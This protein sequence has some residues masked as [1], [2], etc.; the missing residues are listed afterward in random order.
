MVIYKLLEGSYSYDRNIEQGENNLYSQDDVMDWA[1]DVANMI[2]D[3]SED[4]ECIVVDD[5]ESALNVLES[6]NE[7]L[8]LVT[9]LK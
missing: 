7:Y 4:D 5:V 9:N 3:E 6:A 8:E 1:Y 2:M